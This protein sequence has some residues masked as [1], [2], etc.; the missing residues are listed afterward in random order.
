MPQNLK[1]IWLHNM[2]Q[3][4]VSWES[5]NHCNSFWA[6]CKSDYLDAS[7]ITVMQIHLFEPPGDILLFLKGRAGR[8]RHAAEILFERM[9]SSGSL[10]A[11]PP[12][13][14]G[15]AI[16]NAVEDLWA[17]TSWLAQR[18]WLPQIL[19]RQVSPLSPSTAFI[20][21]LILASSSK[22]RSKTARCHLMPEGRCRREGNRHREEEKPGVYYWGEWCMGRETEAQGG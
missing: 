5:G 16:G 13:V 2:E 10:A 4:W 21:S 22:T 19:R 9:R 8:S 1:C 12:R 15:A 14:F 18:W 6:N 3:Y 7:L 11:Y 17:C 20:M